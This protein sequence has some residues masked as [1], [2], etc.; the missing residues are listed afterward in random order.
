MVGLREYKSGWSKNGQCGSG[1]SGALWGVPAADLHNT[2]TAASLGAI[3][4]FCC[5]CDRRKSKN[6]L[7]KVAVIALFLHCASL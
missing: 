3:P 7:Y 2:L 6:L 1:S 4:I 5:E